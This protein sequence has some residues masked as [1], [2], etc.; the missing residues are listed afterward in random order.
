MADAM[1]IAEEKQ[2]KISSEIAEHEAAIA[3]LREEAEML[4]DFLEFG[5]TL[6]ANKPMQ[7]AQNRDEFDAA[8]PFP[9]PDEDHRPPR[10]TTRMPSRTPRPVAQS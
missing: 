2:N 4:K 10:V 7:A 6:I 1:K 5:E 9:A 8:V 3:R